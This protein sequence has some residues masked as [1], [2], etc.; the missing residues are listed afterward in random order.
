MRRQILAKLLFTT[1][2]LSTLPAF[3]ES[4]V[5]VFDGTAADCPFTEPTRWNNDSH[6]IKIS[7]EN[8]TIILKAMICNG[9]QFVR[10][11]KLAY[12][13]Y[14]APNGVLAY[15]KYSDF[16]LVMQNTAN[17]ARTI[18]IAL[19][20]FL[21]QYQVQIPLSQIHEVGNTVDLYI[22]AKVT[23]GN[24]NGGYSDFNFV[25]YGAHRIQF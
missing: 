13:E 9:Q 10:D 20:H 2:F 7:R 17:P 6:F 22:E 21:E 5:K 3:S 18:R 24:V 16:I 14:L 4:I 23:F 12:R 25:K 8:E 19:P 1:F 15:E 11:S